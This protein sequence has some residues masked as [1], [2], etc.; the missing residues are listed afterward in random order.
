MACVVALWICTANI[1]VNAVTVYI[2]DYGAVPNDTR[3][4]TAAIQA[5]LNQ[6]GD[7]YFPKGTY[8]VSSSLNVIS[9]SNLSGP[10][11]LKLSDKA[12]TNIPILS[13]SNQKSWILITGLTLDGNGY[14]KNSG[15]NAGAVTVSQPSCNEITISNL[16]IINARDH[17]IELENATKVSVK[18]CRITGFTRRGINIVF[19]MDCTIEGNYLDGVSGTGTHRAEHGIQIWGNWNKTIAAGNLT[20]TGNIVKNVDG[21]GIWGANF[22]NSVITG[23]QVEE[24]GDV[25]IDLEG[26]LN[27]SVTENSVK[28]CVNGC[29]TTFYGSKSIA[30]RGNQITQLINCVAAIKIY[31]G[32]VS[33]NLSITGNNIQVTLGPYCIYSDMAALAN[34]SIEGNEMRNERGAGIRLL[35]ADK[36]TITGNKIVVGNPAFQADCLFGIDICGGN[37]GIINDNYLES[38]HDDS[39][40]GSG[41]G[42]YLYWADSSHPCQKNTVT[43]NVIRGFITSINDNCWGN[44]ASYNC[45]ENNRVNTIYRRAGVYYNG[46]ID[47]NTSIDDPNITINETKY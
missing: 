25:G 44:N 2:T 40:A 34:S 7:I 32:G 9:D 8:L 26:C 23:N 1:R 13:I 29:I 27:V 43:N 12:T 10:G 24:C 33:Q 46:L 30:I 4:D 11:T 31:G 41:G 15:G 42:I 38:L 35:N 6:G 28:N 3:D 37:D 47:S 45:I 17:G 19:C 5:A 39:S 22:E 16:T 14:A 18:S 21:G 20:I 36:M